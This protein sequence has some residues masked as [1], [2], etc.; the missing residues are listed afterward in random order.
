MYILKSRSKH[1]FDHYVHPQLYTNIHSTKDNPRNIRIN[2]TRLSQ[3]YM[4]LLR[5]RTCNLT[6]LTHRRSLWRKLCIYHLA[7][8]I[9]FGF[10]ILNLNPVR[11]KLSPINRITQIKSWRKITHTKKGMMPR[12]IKSAS[13]SLHP[14]APTAVCRMARG[15]ISEYLRETELYISHTYRKKTHVCS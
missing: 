7:I 5:L 1:I 9:T 13:S 10:Y 11:K 8:N 14:F 15:H 2:L 3:D 12:T 4:K 6:L